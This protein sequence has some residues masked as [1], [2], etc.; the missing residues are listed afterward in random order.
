VITSP[1]SGQILKYD[2]T[3]WINGTVDVIEIQ[4]F[5]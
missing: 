1:V 4:V 5:S 3:K 2:G